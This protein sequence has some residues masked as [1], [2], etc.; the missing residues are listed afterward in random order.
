MWIK[1]CGI[2]SPADAELA[3]TLGADALGL[4]FVPGSKRYLTL[5]DAERVLAP[6]RGKVE[7]VAVVAG[8]A[9]PALEELQSRLRLDW[10]Q[11]HGSEPPEALLELSHA[12][13]AVGIEEPADVAHARSFPG[14]RL[15]VD[16]K[17]PGELG[18]TGRVFDWALVTE[19][20]RERELVLAGGLT[21]DN[22]AEAIE[23]VAPFGVDVA[24]GVERP[25]LPRE[26][27][28]ERLSAFIARARRAAARRG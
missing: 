22:V 19:L 12:Y 15:L 4:N 6:V 11:L 24:S 8:L 13:K 7:L 20:S 17:A 2:S 9:R 16:K 18:G 26:K 28:P 21:P 27:D 14:Q 3:V 25:G 5:D 10:L 1:I 23:R